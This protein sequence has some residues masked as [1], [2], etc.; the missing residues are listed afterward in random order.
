MRIFLYF[1]RNWLF[2]LAALAG[3]AAFAYQ[4]T[5][6]FGTWMF[7]CTCLLPLLSLILALPSMFS[8]RLHCTCPGTAV[9]GEHAE[10]TAEASGGRLSMPLPV[11][12]HITEENCT[13]VTRHLYH[14]CDGIL[15]EH[16]AASAKEQTD[17]V[18]SFS[19]AAENGQEKKNK[20]A[21]GAKRDD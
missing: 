9:R 7:L 13:D 6:W 5:G 11:L 2:Y 8:V 20:K 10:L 16:A 18:P 14:V 1:L 17:T 19:D 3:M 4:Y 21:G 15:S 12:I